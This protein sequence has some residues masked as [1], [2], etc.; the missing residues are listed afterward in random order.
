MP[1]RIGVKGRARRAARPAPRADP[2]CSCFRLRRAA[3]RL[4]QA[5]D[6]A[7]RPAG[8]RGTQFSLLSHVLREDGLSVTDLAER[9]AM[10]RTTLTRNLRPLQ[11]AGL[12]RVEPGADRRSR[13]VRITA[14]GRQAFEAA[15]PL[16]RAAERDFRRQMGKE[17]VAALHRLLDQAAASLVE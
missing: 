16:W 8:L 3:R 7:L 12:L 15:L 10:E 13:A 11:K 14:Q 1:S 2:P 17:Q 9:M 4:T 5:Y 6:Q